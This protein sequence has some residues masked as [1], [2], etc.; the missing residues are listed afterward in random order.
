MKIAIIGA[1]P[2]G[3]YAGYL[4]AKSGHNVSIY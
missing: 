1:G 2:I 3:C 4:L